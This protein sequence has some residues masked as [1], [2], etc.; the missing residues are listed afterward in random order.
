MTKGQKR[1]VNAEMF[2]DGIPS[3]EVGEELGITHTRV[4]QLAQ[5]SLRLLWRAP[6]IGRLLDLTPTEV[7]M[8]WRRSRAVRDAYSILS[9]IER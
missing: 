4:D 6:T 8:A 1:S 2:L 3:R 7:V 5:Q 9:R